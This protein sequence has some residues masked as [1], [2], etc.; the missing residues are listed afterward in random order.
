MSSVTTRREE[1]LLFVGIDRPEKRNALD[2]AVID[3]L[4]EVLDAAVHDPT[5]IILH[6]TSPGVFV[7]GADIGQL[8]ERRGADAVRRIN[9]A[10]FDK[11]A[12]HRWPTIAAIDGPA[13]GG[14]CELTLACDFRIATRNARFSQPEPRLGIMAA[15]GANW[16][17]AAT[18]GL[19]TARR[20]LLAGETLSLDDALACG[21]VDYPS[22]PERLMDDAQELAG[23]I[24]QSSWQALEFTK[25]AL[26]GSTERSTAA[27]DATAQAV[28][29]DSPEKDARMDA[30][31]ARRKPSTTETKGRE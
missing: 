22:E 9:G 13:L 10:L 14:G 23:R 24:G 8:R 19:P 2:Q 31:L 27:F 15:A 30:F 12:A 6:S 17:L 20:M 1:H 21:L 3:E 28:L 16:R 18:V 4:H 11:L 26:A 7:S 25:I 5:V 29:F